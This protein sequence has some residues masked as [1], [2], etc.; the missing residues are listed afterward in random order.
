[1]L[2]GY[3]VYFLVLLY[4]FSWRIIIIPTQMDYSTLFDLE[5]TLE[6]RMGQ[7]RFAARKLE[8][9]ASKIQ[10]ATPEEIKHTRDDLREVNKVIMGI[11]FTEAKYTHIW[12]K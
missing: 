9:I 10:E 11:L 2:A 6:T 4:Q 3:L 8:L 5:I 7:L 1:M 12:N